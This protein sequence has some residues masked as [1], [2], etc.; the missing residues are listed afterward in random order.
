MFSFVRHWPWTGSHAF[1]SRSEKPRRTLAYARRRQHRPGPN[2]VLATGR[3]AP[4]RGGV[5]A[6]PNPQAQESGSRC[7]SQLFHQPLLDPRALPRWMMLVSGAVLSSF[8][9]SRQ[10]IVKE[11][12]PIQILPFKAVIY[13][14]SWV[15]QIVNICW[16]VGKMSVLQN[17]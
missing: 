2:T 14:R 17:T 8:T 1:R 9:I 11:V 4:V 16:C 12:S 13:S 7:I 15:S 6:A 10:T 5:L 3:V